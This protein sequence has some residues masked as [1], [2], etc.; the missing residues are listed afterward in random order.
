MNL[1]QKLNGCYYDKSRKS[2]YKYV[3]AWI[4]NGTK[5]WRA[6]LSNQHFPTLEYSWSAIF[7]SERKAALEVDKKMLSIGREPVNILKRQT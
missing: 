1:P 4:K 7:E 2:K 3:G 6:H 5:I